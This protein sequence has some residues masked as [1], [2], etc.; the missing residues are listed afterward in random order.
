MGNCD[1]Q[2]GSAVQ[3][4]A[5]ASASA[6]AWVSASASAGSVAAQFAAGCA[7]VGGPVNSGNCNVS[8]PG[9]PDQQVPLDAIGTMN[10]GN[11]DANKAGCAQ[12][13]QNAASSAP[14]GSPWSV[15]PVFHSDTGI[16]I[17]GEP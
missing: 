7:V 13:I 11:Y 1:S 9:F 5:S 2:Q 12:G 17:P 3:A 14:D 6:V 8:Y 15:L 16:C 10:Q 4:Q